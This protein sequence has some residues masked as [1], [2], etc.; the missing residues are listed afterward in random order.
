ML[1][2]EREQTTTVTATNSGVD[3]YP[4][5]TVRYSEKVVHRVADLDPASASVQGDY[6]I[7]VERPGRTLSWSGVLELR[8]DRDNFHY[9]Y[10]RR[11]R[12]GDTL[13]REKSWKETIPRDFQ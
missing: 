2:D 5:A 1:R 7:T 9:D 3:E 11:L 12:E 10:T 4:F 6:S 13:L 8:S